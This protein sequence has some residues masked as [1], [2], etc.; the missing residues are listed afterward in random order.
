MR[1]ARNAARMEEMKD[2]YKVLVEEPG[3]KKSL[4][5]PKHR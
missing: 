2:E 3:G 1:W 5:R 4:G